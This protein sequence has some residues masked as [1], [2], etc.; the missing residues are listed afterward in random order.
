MGL[1]SFLMIHSRTSASKVEIVL[2]THL[3]VE[4]LAMYWKIAYLSSAGL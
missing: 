1:K 4:M 2:N 3:Q